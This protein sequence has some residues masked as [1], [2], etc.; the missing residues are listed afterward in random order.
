MN[1]K[2]QYLFRF[3]SNTAATCQS[4]QMGRGLIRSNSCS[5]LIGPSGL[6]GRVKD[7]PG[8]KSGDGRDDAQQ[9]E[10]RISQK[11]LHGPVGVGGGV[12]GGAGG[13]VAQGNCEEQP[14]A[15]RYRQ[16]VHP[17][18]RKEQDK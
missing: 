17:C 4:V 10:E 15:E 2:P 1:Q 18:L 12:T 14:H 6:R 16:P 8:Q 9:V 13:V 7:V 3:M 5:S 11:S